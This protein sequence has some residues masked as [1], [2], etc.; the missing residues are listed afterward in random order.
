MKVVKDTNDVYHSHPS[1]SASGIKTIVSESVRYLLDGPKFTETPAMKLGT[2]IHVAML[3]PELWDDLYY[4]MPFIENGRTK[5]GIALKKKSL[6]EADG[7]IMLKH[8]EHQKVKAIMAEYH[9]Q[10]KMSKLARHYCS[11]DVE[12]SHYM[13]YGGVG[14]RVRPDV[15]NLEKGFIAD[16]KSCQN[17]NPR[18]FKRDALNR[19]YHVQAAFYMDM[20]SMFYDTEITEFRF[21]ACMTNP[22]YTV[23]V[24]ALSKHYI[25]EG[26]LMYGAA[27]SD[28]KDY[29]KNGIIHGPMWNDLH[30]D[31]SLII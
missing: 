31:G 7:K 19:N 16:V 12:L 15:L 11:G 9:K 18:I 22:P 14:V 24:I 21:I 20:I 2:A 30:E 1:I 29:V 28:W 5:E 26:R 8:E 4:E 13:D 3:E 17:S 10:T 23:N 6:E 27:L 25:E